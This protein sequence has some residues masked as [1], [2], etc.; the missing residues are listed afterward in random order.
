[1]RHFGLCADLIDEPQA[2]RI[3]SWLHAAHKLHAAFKSA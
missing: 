1:M 3:E 2:P